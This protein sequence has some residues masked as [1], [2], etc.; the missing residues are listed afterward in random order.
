MPPAKRKKNPVADQE[1]RKA[2]RCAA[3]A[4]VSG[5]DSIGSGSLPP[6]RTGGVAV[7]DGVGGT[8]G[9]SAEELYRST[10]LAN[11]A[12][13]AAAKAAHDSRIVCYAL[14]MRMAESARAR[15]A[16]THPPAASPPV[17]LPPATHP[18]PAQW[19][20]DSI[21]PCCEWEVWNWR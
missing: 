12:A 13:Q 8:T 7:G 20:F 6:G 19:Y 14:T 17:E 10:Q 4:G 9:L 5:A 16:A 18:P 21:C 2:V 1:G 11:E 3:G 15:G